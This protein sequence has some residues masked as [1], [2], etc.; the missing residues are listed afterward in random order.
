M[1]PRSGNPRERMI[2]SAALLMR[3]HGVEAT[4]FSEVLA[5]SGAPRGSIYHHFP[6]GK[7]ELIEEATRFAGEF[8]RQAAASARRERGGDPLTTLDLNARF[9][10]KVLGDSNF[11]AGCPVAAGTLESER[12]PAVRDAAGKFFA[13]WQEE[14]A[15]TLI[16]SG[17]DPARA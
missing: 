6:G 3:E 12:T 4:S 7:T 10:K 16:Q 15:K 11:S 9:W 5:H 14:Y 17:V 1:S 2:Q 8:I 13:G